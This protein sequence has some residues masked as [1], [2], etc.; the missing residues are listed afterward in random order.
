M[1]KKSKKEQNKQLRLLGQSAILEEA[2]TPYLIRTTMF[3]I[4]IV[5]L[6]FIGWTSVAKIKEM[7]RTV[8]EIVP[9]GHIQ[10]IQHLEGGIVE[11]ILVREDEVV[12]KGQVLLRLSGEAVRADLDR[13]QTRQVILETRKKRMLAFLEGD[14]LAFGDDGL[15]TENGQQGSV[16]QGQRQILE[17]ML[18]AH[19]TEKK[20]IVEQIIQKKEQIAMLRREQQTVAANLK[21]AESAFATQQEL[22]DERLIPETTYLDAVK[23]K[24]ERRGKL[25]TIDIQLRQAAKVVKEFEW[26][27]R[28]LES[29]SKDSTLQQIGALDSELAENSKLVAKLRQQAERLAIK[30]PARGVVKGLETHT[31]GGVVERGQQLMEIVP[32]GEELIAEVRVSPTDIGHI[33]VGDHV[34]VKITSFDFSRYGSIGGTVSAL[35]ATTFTSEQG[36]PYYKG[37]VRLKQNYVGLVPGR[38]TILPG[39]IVNADIV[40]GEKSI[41]A[42]LLKPIHISLTTAFVER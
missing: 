29:S 26:R 6:T 24:N 15:G 18:Q 23:E 13:L 38:N 30:A 19:A 37:I 9:S 5:F 4:S 3:V 21:V 2:T 11:E 1:K 22:Y 27:L 12:A 17:G 10:A 20:V 28:S 40:T 42:Y 34:D 7:A 8:G 16:A 39:M 31:I 14:V 32:L 36:A 35:S 41:L 33:K 25:E